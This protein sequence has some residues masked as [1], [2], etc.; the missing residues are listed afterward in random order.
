METFLI[1]LFIIFMFLFNL[2]V[3]WMFSYKVYLMGKR[4]FL[5]A[6]VY[7]GFSTMF[8]ALFIGII[9][10]QFLIMDEIWAP[11]V[12]IFALTISTYIGTIITPKVDK[13]LIK[14]KKDKEK[15]KIK[16]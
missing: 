6:A 12:E 15:Y 7:G 1:I 4:K 9:S 3:Q 5:R 14:R 10:L 8:G 13:Y 16:K 2:L 11:I